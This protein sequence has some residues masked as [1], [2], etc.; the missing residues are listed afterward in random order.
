MRLLKY[1]IVITVLVQGSLAQKLPSSVSVPQWRDAW[2]AQWQSGN[3]DE[4]T[5]AL[6]QLSALLLQLD[7][8]APESLELMDRLEPLG[9]QSADAGMAVAFQTLRRG[10]PEKSSRHLLDL[11]LKYAADPRVNRFRIGLAR[12]FRQD[13]Q[14]DLAAAQ[15]EP[16]MNLQTPTGRWATL[17]RALLYRT[18]GA[19]EDAI[20][21]LEDLEKAAV[22]VYLKQRIEQEKLEAS[23]NRL[24]TSE[25]SQTQ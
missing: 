14:F 2:I 18:Q 19:D 21:L 11:I 4:K 3:S 20:R 24:V 9:N 6:S 25:V 16:I 22:N 17:E 23:F 12:A 13:G 5:R 8:D 1:I 10:F 15:L 7:V